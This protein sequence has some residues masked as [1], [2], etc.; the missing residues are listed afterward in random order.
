M[1]RY[2]LPDFTANLGLNLFFARL[3]MERPDWMQDDVCIDTM[4]GSFPNCILNGGR[5][6]LRERY[7]EQQIDRT[8]AILDE[9]GIRPRLTFTNML[10]DEESLADGY[11]N[12]ILR[13][14]SQHGGQVIAYS[15]LVADYVRERFDMPVI[16]ST[17]REILDIDE[18][19]QALDHYDWVVLNYNLNKRDDVLSQVKHPEKLEVM[20]N[21]FC[22]PNCPHRQDH[23]LHNSRGQLTGDLTPYPCIANKPDFFQHPEGHPTM[24]TDTEVRAYGEDYGIEYFKIV[25]RGTVFDTLLES[26]SYYLVKPEYRPIVKREVQRLRQR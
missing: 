3:F 18:L 20:V 17:T 24:F 16:L 1:I 10:V 13:K 9:Y 23:Y 14:A 21:E 22:M 4:Y 15:D 26:F 7:T 5:T 11:A 8:F 19:N 6:Y 25:G 12:L 2:E